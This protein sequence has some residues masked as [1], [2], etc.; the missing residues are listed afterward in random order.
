MYSDVYKVRQKEQKQLRKKEN[1]KLYEQV[2]ITLEEKECFEKLVEKK[3]SNVLFDSEKDDWL[4]E[5]SVFNLRLLNKENVCILIEDDNNNKFGGVVS[6]KIQNTNT[7]LGNGNSFIFSLTKNGE[8]NC[9]KYT[10]NN[11]F[12]CG[13]EFILSP[14]GHKL[15]F[16][17]GGCKGNDIRVYKKKTD[18]SWCSPC[19]YTAKAGDLTGTYYFEPKRIVV[20]QLI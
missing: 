18:K 11:G 3:I 4:Q 19:T 14:K 15:L 12:E 5:T 8:R 16:M 2:N 20:F 1:I 13:N 7:W 17:F 9:K 10:P 6:C